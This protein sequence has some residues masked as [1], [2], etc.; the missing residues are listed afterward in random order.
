MVDEW[1]TLL[2][3]LEREDRELRRAMEEEVRTLFSSKSSNEYRIWGWAGHYHPV[4]Y[5]SSNFQA[6]L[7]SLAKIVTNLQDFTSL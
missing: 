7:N 3:I 6:V 1:N 2:A 5:R 4:S